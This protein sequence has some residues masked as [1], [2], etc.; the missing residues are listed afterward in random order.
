MKVIIRE[1]AYDDLDRIFDWIART[2]HARRMR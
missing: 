1:G 2:G